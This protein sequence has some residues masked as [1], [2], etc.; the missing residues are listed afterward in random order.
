MP[1]HAASC[2]QFWLVRGTTSYVCAGFRYCWAAEL[3]RRLRSAPSALVAANRKYGATNLKKSRALPGPGQF[4]RSAPYAA[5]GLVLFA[6]APARASALRG[7]DTWTFSA[8]G[9]MAALGWSRLDLLIDSMARAVEHGRP[10][11]LGGLQGELVILAFEHSPVAYRVFLV[12]VTGAMAAA[13]VGLLRALRWSTAMCTLAVVALA[14]TLQFRSYHDAVLGYYGTTQVTGICVLLSLRDFVLHLRSPSRV[15][16][17]RSVVLLTAACLFN[18]WAIAMSG[19]HVAIALSERRGWAAWRSAGLPLA[20]SGAVGAVALVMRR[21]AAAELPTNYAVATSPVAVLR[22]WFIQLI[23]P[24]PMTNQLFDHN[25]VQYL[26]IPGSATTAEVAVGALRGLVVCVAAAACIFV[27]ARETAATTS[28]SRVGAGAAG[29]AALLLLP[30]ALIAL[31]PKYQAELN[32]AKG[33]LV[34]TVQALGVAVLLVA[35]TV[36]VLRAATQRSRVATALVSGLALTGLVVAAV[37]DGYNNARVVALEVPVAATQALL[38]DALHHGALDHVG[39]GEAILF[40]SRDLRWPTGTLELQEDALE[41]VVRTH[42]GRRF[43]ARL[44]SAGEI[45]AC[46]RTPQ[47]PDCEP[48]PEV[49]HWLRV[50]A[51]P[52]GGSVIVATAR[53]AGPLAE[54]VS[55]EIRVFVR[56]ASSL[57][58]VGTAADGGRWQPTDRLRSTAVEGRWRSWHM[59]PTGAAPLASTLDDPRGA[60]DFDNLSSPGENVRLFG[61]ERLLP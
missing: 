49:V 26:A 1:R 57:A 14:A 37:V 53:L 51:W 11:V 17:T 22:T 30:P 52:G 38:E 47:N 19:A 43:D 55:T 29:G 45:D 8:T 6:L 31:A 44:I 61:T 32:A 21:L 33:Y 50:R 12:F 9:R 48:L 27:L 28:L 10:Q 35:L 34:S 24:W 23:P 3:H 36:V 40:D 5:I 2:R 7:D 46:P 16:I 42:S 20:V 59:T 39:G 58:L 13:L 18:E 54:A 15:R 56:D 25:G 4:A 41:W 60:V